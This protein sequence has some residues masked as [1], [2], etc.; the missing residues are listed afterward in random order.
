MAAKVRVTIAYQLVRPTARAVR[1]PPLVAGALL[2]LIAVALPAALV[3]LRPEGWSTV[4]RLAALAGATGAAFILDDPSYPSTSVV[5]TPSLLRRTVAVALLLPLAALWWVAALLTLPDDAATG[6]PLAG[7][8]IEAAALF[9]IAIAVAAGRKG[10]GGLAGAVATLVTG[11][12][13]RLPQLD[14]VLP[15]G[16]PQ[17]NRAH[18]IWAV[19]AAAACSAFV[20]GPIVPARRLRCE[21]FR[22]RLV[23]S[24]VRRS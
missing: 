18:L 21:N 6:L 15:P 4:L 1:W 3:E 14:L 23:G 17:W 19:L 10:D 13:A 2:G 16:D 12:L 8:T 11:L 5:P 9:A 24:G 7:L 20:A 22:R